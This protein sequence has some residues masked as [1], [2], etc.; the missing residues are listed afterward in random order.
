MFREILQKP[1]EVSVSLCT[2]LLTSNTFRQSFW[3]PYS[4]PPF[5]GAAI[6]PLWP[7]VTLPAWLTL[8]GQAPHQPANPSTRTPPFVCTAHEFIIACVNKLILYQYLREI[9]LT[10]SWWMTDSVVT[11]RHS[12]NINHLR[13]QRA[14]VDWP[15]KRIFKGRFKMAHYPTGEFKYVLPLALREQHNPSA[16]QSKMKCRTA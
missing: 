16:S 13:R 14:W 9:S 10:L 2:N 15:A 8:A 6:I 5:F 4:L 7:A 1:K 12:S 3:P 11:I